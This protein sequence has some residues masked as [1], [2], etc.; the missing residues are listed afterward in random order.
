MSAGLRFDER[1]LIKCQLEDLTAATSFSGEIGVSD[2]GGSVRAMHR[3]EK[4]RR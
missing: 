2:G 1:C 3:D 4:R